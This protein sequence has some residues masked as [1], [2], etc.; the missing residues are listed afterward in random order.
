[1]WIVVSVLEHTLEENS[2]ESPK[3][4]TGLYT[5]FLLV[6]LT[7]KEGKEKKENILISNQEAILKLGNLAFESLEKDITVFHEKDLRE[8]GININN[9]SLYSGVCKEIFNLF[10]EKVY[11]FLHLTVQ[12]YF[13]ALYIFGS[14]H[15]N[16][17]NPLKKKYKDS[18]LKRKSK[19]TLNKNA[20][21]RAI[22]SSNGHLDFFVRFLLG[23]EIENNQKLLKGFLL[24]SQDY[25]SDIQKTA[26]HIKKRIKTTSSPERCMNLFRCLSELKDQSLLDEFNVTLDV[27]NSGQSLSP[28][29]CSALAYFSLLSD[30]FVFDVF[31]VFDMS[32][33][34]TSEEC[35]WRLIPVA[36]TC[37]ASIF[38]SCNTQPKTQFIVV[39]EKLLLQHSNLRELD[40][41]VNKLGDSAVKLFFVALMHPNCKLKT[42]RMV[43]CG[44]TKRCCE[45]LV[46]ALQSQY[47]TLKE[48]D[49]KLNNIQQTESV[50]KHTAIDRVPS[51]GKCLNVYRM[52]SC[53]LTEKCCEG[54]ASAVRSPHNREL[55]L[56]ENKLGDSGVKLLSAALRDP[57]CKLTALWMLSCG[58]TKKCC[59]D[60]AS[61]IQSRH[62]SLRKLDLSYN[63]LGDSGMK[64][65]TAALKDPN[66][67]L[68]T[69]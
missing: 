24:H 38:S 19:L 10:E 8:Y 27:K 44:L 32:K 43:K 54:L 61:V 5:N 51:P 14:N 33:Y 42:L 15:N 46:S 30:V 36:K 66:C 1:C 67:K 68:E 9:S 56:S 59:K 58:L 52:G 65:L 37:R 62:S 12:E 11:S 39:M 17:F 49:L 25:P 23:I 50:L 26:E 69:L 21:E 60:V 28:S 48:L 31:D 3:T 47:S 22:Q 64:L 34:A 55:S 29:Q 16:Y 20:L 45:D 18:T 7:A 2:E 53:G 35:V 40:L 6:L 57:D 41:S 63:D 4:L 13:V